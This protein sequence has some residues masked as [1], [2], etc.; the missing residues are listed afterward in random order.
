MHFTG[1][2]TEVDQLL[3]NLMD[4]SDTLLIR[5]DIEIYM[6]RYS[7]I[8]LGIINIL[9][10]ENLRNVWADFFFDIPPAHL[11]KILNL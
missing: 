6:N 4:R 9:G 1:I 10:K 11:K 7:I 2:K 8:H 5:V 3:H